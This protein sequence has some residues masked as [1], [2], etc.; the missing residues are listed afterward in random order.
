MAFCG[1][2]AWFRAVV[3]PTRDQ[4]TKRTR[5]RQFRTEERLF[6]KTHPEYE[7]TSILDQLRKKEYPTLDKEHHIYLDYTGSGLYSTSQLQAHF[8]LLRSNVFGNPHSV[9][10]TSSA[11]TDLIE[12]TRSAVL[13]FFQASPDEYTVI[14]TSNASHAIK[15]VGEAYPFATTSRGELLLCQDNHNSVLGIR[16]FARDKGAT[17]KYVPITGPELRVDE[18]QLQ[19]ML[20]APKDG[21]GSRLFAYPAQSNFTGVQHPLEWIA[22]AQEQGWDV[23]LDAASFVPTNILDLS[24]WHPDFVP[25]SFYKMFGYPSGIGCLIARKEALTRLNR[26]WFAGGTV[27]GSSVEADN[28]VLLNGAG[29]FE[30]GT[31]NFLTLPAVHIGLNHLA[32]IGICTAHIR[33]S[34]LTNWLLQSLGSLRHSN[35]KPVATIYG[36]QTTEQR[37]G[38]I[39]FNFIDPS[40]VIVDGR[41]VDQRAKS[42]NLSLRTGC[43]CNPGAGEAAFRLSSVA[44]ATGFAGHANQGDKGKGYIQKSFDDFL[45]DIGM[46]SG[47]GVRVSVGL[48]SNFAD[49]YGF[50]QFARTFIDNQPPESNLPQRLHC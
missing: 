6:H 47:G 49:V 28:H 38:S 19:T 40:G 7:E 45:D 50:I 44:I 8:E 39:A 1:L 32:D 46:P 36:P 25:I 34:C 35:G 17:I 37:G 13:R 24:C 42:I 43:F 20:V 29:G 48:V 4:Q 12:K 21:I 16:E 41:I 33:A 2:T 27:W 23:L 26:P 15:L 14:F 5:N 3:D 9:N 10:P 11:I 18:T 30:D 31:L 22:L